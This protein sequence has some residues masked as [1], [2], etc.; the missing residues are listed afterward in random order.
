MTSRM[1]KRF[2]YPGETIVFN[3]TLICFPA[4]KRVNLHV[5]KSSL[6]VGDWRHLEEAGSAREVQSDGQTIRL[7]R[8]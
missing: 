4:D 3:A 7:G 8:Y 6:K 5:H 1:K 2:A